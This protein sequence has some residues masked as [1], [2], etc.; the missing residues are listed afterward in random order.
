MWFKA[1]QHCWHFALALPSHIHYISMDCFFKTYCCRAFIVWGLDYPVTHA[2]NTPCLHFLISS[3]SWLPLSSYYSQITFSSSFS[4]L[5]NF[6]LSARKTDFMFYLII[7]H[8]LWWQ[9]FLFSVN[10]AGHIF[11]CS[12]IFF[13]LHVTTNI[14]HFPISIFDFTKV[15]NLFFHILFLFLC[16]NNSY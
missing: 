9:I 15:L 1:Q 7:F 4:H 10:F 6:C 13:S 14:R 3:T 5:K 2:N 12:N 8:N 16:L 11:L